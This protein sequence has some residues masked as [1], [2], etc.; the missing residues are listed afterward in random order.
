MSATVSSRRLLSTLMRR[1]GMTA[2][3]VSA[4]TQMLSPC[5][6]IDKRAV[7]SS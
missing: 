1:S 4:V 6:V 3:R 7:L 5:H 2:V